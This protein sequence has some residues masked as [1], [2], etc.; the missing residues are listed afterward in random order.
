[1]EI[2]D[3]PQLLREFDEWIFE[4]RP[5]GASVFE[6]TQLIMGLMIRLRQA[7]TFPETHQALHLMMVRVEERLR[8]DDVTLIHPDGTRLPFV[9]AEKWRGIE[10]GH[11]MVT[12]INNP[13][14]PDTVPEDW[15][16]ECG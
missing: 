8:D 4:Q 2:P 14:I 12:A 11:E 3:K 6:G 10:G 9:T 16:G 7:L 13:Q 15:E 5:T 1:M